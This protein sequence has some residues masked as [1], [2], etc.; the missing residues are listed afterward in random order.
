MFLADFLPVFGV[1][2]D[3]AGDGDGVDEDFEVLGE[4]VSFGAAGF[5]GV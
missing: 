2:L 1:G 5:C 3:F 4:A